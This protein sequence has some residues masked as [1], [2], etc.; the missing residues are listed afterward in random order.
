VW[1]VLEE[2]I[3]WSFAVPQV[4]GGYIAGRA[5]NN[6]FVA[7]V[8]DNRNPSH[9]LFVAQDEINTELTLKRREFG[10]YGR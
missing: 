2:S 10:L 1:P 7:T 9:A 4:P 8:I 6:A 5:I 3:D